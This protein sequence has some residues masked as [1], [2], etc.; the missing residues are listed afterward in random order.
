MLLVCRVERKQT[1]KGR[2]SRG[3]ILSRGRRPVN[4]VV[5]WPPW[6]ARAATMGLN[7]ARRRRS[8]RRGA[9]G[10][11]WS[12]PLARGAATWAVSGP[13]AYSRLLAGAAQM[14]LETPCTTA[15]RLRL[16][17]ATGPV[18]EAEDRTQLIPPRGCARVYVCVRACA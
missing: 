1:R 6:A 18:S 14:S 8:L 4:A 5:V 15:A 9:V 3:A 10:S 7:P 11:G 12:L 2:A 17:S 13:I 16:V